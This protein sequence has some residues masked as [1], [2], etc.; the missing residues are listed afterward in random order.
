MVRE[1]KE[2][3]LFTIQE[4]AEALGVNVYTLRQWVKSGKLPANYVGKK[5]QWTGKQ[6]LKA[7]ESK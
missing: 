6:L 4:A 7:V 5:Y 1:I 2:N 3:Q